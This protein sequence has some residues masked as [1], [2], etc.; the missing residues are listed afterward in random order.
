MLVER[1]NRLA[2]AE[3]G[4]VLSSVIRFLTKFFGF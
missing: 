4:N 1:I 2:L 3:H